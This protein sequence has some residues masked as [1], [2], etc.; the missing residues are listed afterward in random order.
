M[1]LF[2]LIKGIVSEIFVPV[3][4]SGQQDDKNDQRGFIK[5]SPAMSCFKLRYFEYFIRYF[6][7]VDRAF[8]VVDRAYHDL[9][10]KKVELEERS[11]Y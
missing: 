9:I 6:D 10:A 4:F 3:L 5:Y 1:V 8:E 11:T 7:L 2:R